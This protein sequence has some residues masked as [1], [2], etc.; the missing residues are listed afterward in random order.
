MSTFRMAMSVHHVAFEKREG[1]ARE[2]FTFEWNEASSPELPHGEA[3][4]EPAR[5]GAPQHE[6][7]DAQPRR[8]VQREA[9]QLGRHDARH[10]RRIAAAAVQP[11]DELPEGPAAVRAHGAQE[12]HAVVLDAALRRGQAVR[13]RLEPEA[14]RDVFMVVATPTRAQE[15]VVVLGVDEGDEEAGGVQEP[16]EVEGGVDV[17]GARVRDEQRVRPLRHDHCIRRGHY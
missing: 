15:G 11:Q 14:T 4:G 1:W 10:R 6:A 12:A 13:D 7:G 16:G 8:H 2:V 5:A 9:H 17:A 3:A